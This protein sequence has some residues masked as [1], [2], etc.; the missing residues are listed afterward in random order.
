MQNLKKRTKIWKQKVINHNKTLKI[1][2]AF[3]IG[4]LCCIFIITYNM[5]YSIFTDYREK[6]IDE[7]EDWQIK[8]DK[9]ETELKER[10][11]TLLEKEANVDK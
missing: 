11:E 10:E 7:Y 6:I 5:D 1:V 9:K 3:L 2:I 8:L 4:I